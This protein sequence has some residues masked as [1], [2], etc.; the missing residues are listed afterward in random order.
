MKHSAL[1]VLFLACGV[2]P[3]S[4]KELETPYTEYLPSEY[5]G[6]TPSR[7]NPFEHRTIISLGICKILS[8]RNDFSSHTFESDALR[9]LDR[10]GLAGLDIHDRKWISAHDNRKDACLVLIK[11]NGGGSYL[12]Q[13]K[14][15]LREILSE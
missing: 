1:I 4:A 13:I 5:R 11:A 12:D 6:G 2:P 7:E 14:A 9:K 10:F 8:G 3:S 15:W